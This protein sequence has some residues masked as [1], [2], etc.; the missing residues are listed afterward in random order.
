MAVFVLDKKGKPLMPCSERRARVLLSRRRARIH[1]L[2]PFTIRL[3]DR[4]QQDSVLQPISCKIDP[5]SQVTGMAL[6]RADE[7]TDSV[8]TLIEI[9]HR[10]HQIRD[11]LTARRAM[12]RAR[13]QRQT[14]YR[15]ARFLNRGN[16]TKGWLA[17]SL[18]HRVQT[19]SHWVKRLQALC[20][21]TSIHQELVK[22]DMQKMQDAEITGKEYQ[23][24][25]LWGMEVKEY[26][27][28]KF[29]HQCMYCDAKECPLEVE[30]IVPRCA[31][32]SHRISNLG[33]ACRPCNQKKGA[34]DLKTF[35]KDT[36]RYQRIAA[37]VKAPLKDAAAVNSTRHALFKV[38]IRFGLPVYTSTG[39]QTKLN[40]KQQ[41]IEKTHA[42]DAV[43]I[44]EI[45]AVQH[46]H[47]PTLHIKCM[48]RGTYQR[49]RLSQYGFPRGYLMRSKFIH[50]FMTGDMIKAQVLT[51]KKTGTYQGRVAIRQS[52]YFNIQTKEGLVQ[53]IHH[54]H[55]K[56]I[57]RAD[58]YD[59]QL[60]A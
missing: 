21:I 28:A 41:G 34:M 42:L 36:K 35:V 17:P 59:Y 55:C 31:G 25:T 26:L 60:V 14:R 56:V 24:G 22:F 30:H 44:G 37:Q 40:R 5:G 46:V 58:G 43:C 27:L 23:Q 29:K 20:P 9:K 4:L 49:T 52:G 19:T 48:G 39:A 57:Q 53:G 16:K 45:R 6:V 47:Q 12:R 51:G 54:R 50:G 7:N 8:V 18:M 32:G 33:L 3:I 11:A 1:K 13:R 2:Y 10:G 38:L 15:Q